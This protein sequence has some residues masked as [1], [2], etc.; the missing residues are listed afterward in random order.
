MLGLQDFHFSR[1]LYLIGHFLFSVG[2][3]Q[4][5]DEAVGPVRIIRQ[6]FGLVIQV[7]HVV[8]VFSQ[9]SAPTILFLATEHDV[10]CLSVFG[11]EYGLNPAVLNT[12][13]HLMER[14]KFRLAVGPWAWHISCELASDDAAN[15]DAAH[16]LRQNGED[17]HMHLIPIPRS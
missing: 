1:I 6:P 8:G 17:L 15:A 4:D 11:R 3:Q 16:C 5:F 7:A 10:I 12:A 14:K 9:W 13:S 2:A